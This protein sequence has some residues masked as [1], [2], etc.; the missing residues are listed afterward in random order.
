MSSGVALF[1]NGVEG[2]RETEKAFAEYGDM[3]KGYFGFNPRFSDVLVPLFDD[4]FSRDFYVGF[5]LLASYWKIPLTDSS[6]NPVW[7]YANKHHL[8]ILLHTWNDKYNSPA[9]LIETV[10]QYPNAIFLLGHSGGGTSGRFEAIELAQN[11]DNVYLEFCGSFTTSELFEEAI[12]QVGIEKVIYGSDTSG[13]SEVWELGRFLS[14]PLNDDE[15]RPV[16]AQNIENIFQ[17][18]ALN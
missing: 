16:L 3:F 17:K 10:K 13:H 8:P 6:Y 1:G 11:N 14:L 2:N 15:L 4:F 12:A 7:E 5:K 9:M 18:R